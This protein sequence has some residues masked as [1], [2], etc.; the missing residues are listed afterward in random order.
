[1]TTEDVVGRL[2]GRAPCSGCQRAY[3]A[4]FHPPSNHDECDDCG[5]KLVRREEDRPEAVRNRLDVYRAQTTPV[6]D[7]YRAAGKLVEIDGG[8]AID[9]VQEALIAAV[10]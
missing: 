4:T 8:Q 10:E 9:A 6:L 2:D 1:M 5:A 3:H 7:H